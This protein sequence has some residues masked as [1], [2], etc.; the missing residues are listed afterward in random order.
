VETA[1]NRESLVALLR[2]A[3]LKVWLK[4]D[5]TSDTVEF[6]RSIS[7]LNHEL[8]DRRYLGGLD[9]LEQFA[10]AHQANGSDAAL[11]IALAIARELAP[12]AT[13]RPASEQ[14]HHLVNFLQRHFRPLENTDELAVREQSVRD[15]LL[16]I[17]RRMADARQQHHDVMWTIDD[18]AAAVR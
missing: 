14:I 6:A 3:H 13:A 16:E 5:T 11:E 10:A 8:S 17:L 15:A 9:R 12:L 1:F 7:E 4:P 2:S 18:L